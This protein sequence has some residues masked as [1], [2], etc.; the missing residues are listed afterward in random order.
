MTL[1]G[2]IKVGEVDAIDRLFEELGEV[3]VERETREMVV[4]WA[5][6]M[7]GRE[8]VRNGEGRVGEWAREVLKERE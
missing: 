8:R 3:R 2:L 1:R 7:R 4:R 6:G 5:V